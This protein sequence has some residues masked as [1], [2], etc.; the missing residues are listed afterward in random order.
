MYDA[1]SHT[2]PYKAAWSQADT[3]AYMARM[4]GIQCDPH[5]TDLFMDMMAEAADDLPSF[6]ASLEEGASD[7]PHI[8]AETRMAKALTVRA[9]DA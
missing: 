1:L 7:S 2:R 6:L 8:V 5:D 4:R 9:A 3:L